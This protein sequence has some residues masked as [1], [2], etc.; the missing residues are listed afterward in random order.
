MSRLSRVGKRFALGRLA[1]F[2][3]FTQLDAL[4]TWVFPLAEVLVPAQ[5]RPDWTQEW[6]AELWQLRNGGR[7]CRREHGELLETLSLAHGLVADAMWLRVDWLK[8]SAR[9]SAPWCLTVLACYCLLCAG[10]ERALVGSW[11]SFFHVLVAHFFGSFIFVAVPAVFAAISTYPLRPLKCDG[12]H[13]RASRFFSARARWNLFLGAK[14]VLTLALGFLAT[15][16]ATAP[17]RMMMGHWAPWAL[18]WAELLMSVVMVTVGLRWA[19][20]NQERRCQKCLRMLG[21]PTRVGPPSRNFLDW[22]GTE[23]VCADGHG[24]LHVPEIEGSW[25]WYDRWVELDPAWQSLFTA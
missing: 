24:R 18:D 14:V 12:G 15:V 23:L 19:L 1:Q 11:S 9:G 7:K 20:L 10:M 22:N 13:A 25:C 2:G 16:V 21:Q 8:E 5:K 6:Q 4:D 17:I 3:Q